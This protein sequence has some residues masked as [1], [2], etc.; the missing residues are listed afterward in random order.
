M[1]GPVIRKSLLILFS[2]NGTTNAHILNY[3][4]MKM[5]WVR[6]DGIRLVCKKLQLYYCPRGSES[7]EEYFIKQ[8]LICISD[9]DTR[10]LVFTSETMEL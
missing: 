5:K 10:A 4:V 8:N 6:S 9:V 2:I 1:T 7:L 3:G